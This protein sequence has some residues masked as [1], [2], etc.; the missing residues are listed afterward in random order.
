VLALLT[1]ASGAHAIPN[2]ISYQ[3][4]IPFP[5]NIGEFPF[6]GTSSGGLK[7]LLPERRSSGHDIR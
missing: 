6:A 3:G 5:A 7:Q 1:A 4:S 2:F